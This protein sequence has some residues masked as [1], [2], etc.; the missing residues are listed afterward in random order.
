MA[1][2]D[3]V[4]E[5]GNSDEAA[6][7]APGNRS[8]ETTAAEMPAGDSQDALR[9]A[10]QAANARKVE[11]TR[12]RRMQALS[13]RLDGFH[14]R[15]IAARLGVGVKTA[16]ADV[17][18]QL[19]ELN[20]VTFESLDARRSVMLLQLER[21]KRGLVA[22]VNTGDTHATD[23]LVKIL[24]RE[25][26][27]VGADAPMKMLTRVDLVDHQARHQATVQALCDNFSIEEL[28]VLEK[29]AKLRM[30]H[31]GRV[32]Q[33]DRV[34][35]VTDVSPRVKPKALDAAVIDDD[36]SEPTPSAG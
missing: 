16:F 28:R 14:Y 26:R 23:S 35:V 8:P 19:A 17:K 29:A 36:D 13:L 2:D 12:A 15:E 33:I 27:L 21:A 7:D 32:E 30:M 20:A 34:S 24:D 10:K 18:K 9:A 3:Q 25:S 31:D 6:L 11:T 1:D 22:K 5:S 4:D